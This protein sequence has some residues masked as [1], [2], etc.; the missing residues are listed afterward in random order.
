MPIS[1]SIP[2]G[3]TPDDLAAADLRS[4]DF[5][6][7]GFTIS[8]IDA[9][10]HPRF[11]EGYQALWDEFGPRNEMEQR[12]VI[13]QR[14]TWRPE[15]PLHSLAMQYEMIV[16]S[17]DDEV[18]AVSDHT[19][20]VNVAHPDQP[21]IVHLSHLLLLPRFRGTGL[22][23]WMR[24]MPIRLARDCLLRSGQSLRRIT[25]AAEVEPAD[26]MLPERHQRLTSFQKVGFLK[27][28]QGS[29]DYLQPDFRPSELI[30]RE[31]RP[32]PVPLSLLLRRLGREHEREIT[33]REL[34]ALVESLYAMYEE[35]LRPQDMVPMWQ[36]LEMYPE[37]DERVALVLPTR[38]T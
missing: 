6:W 21:A 12:S 28:D 26:S 29:I 17:H 5:D 37:G 13:E 2:L 24:A 11:A 34:R 35:T 30:D 3:V 7:T 23:G 8:F 1:A 38:I 25:L 9:P 33:G 19:A 10:T 36:S 15:Q 14:M 4:A 27:V 22:S 20:I 18:A 31:G 16:V 32:L